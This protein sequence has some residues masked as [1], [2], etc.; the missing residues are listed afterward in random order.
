MGSLDDVPLD[1]AEAD[2]R[3]TIEKKAPPESGM[4]VL[5]TENAVTLHVNG[6]THRI[7][8]SCP[9][10]AR[11]ESAEQRVAQVE[12]EADALYARLNESRADL[13]QEIA[14]LR[15]ENTKL[16][17]AHNAVR[18]RVAALQREVETVQGH[19]PTLWQRIKTWFHG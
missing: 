19:E 9:E 12:T 2:P 5:E 8:L 17:Q 1:A 13:W 15:G 14:K 4:D 6:D 16:R 10:R 3:I 18:E 11:V 7:P